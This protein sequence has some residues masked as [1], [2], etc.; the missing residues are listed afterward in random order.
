MIHQKTALISGASRGIGKAIAEK[1]ASQGMIVGLLARN[2]TELQ[3]LAQD[4]EAVGGKALV[5]P[6]DITDEA[7]IQ[8]AVGKAWQIWGKIDLLINNAGIGVFK[9]LMDTSVDD[10]DNVMNTNA[11]GTFLLTKHILPYLKMQR[12]GHIITIASDVSRRNF[13]HGSVYCASK[14]AQDA[15]MQAV[16]QEV[17]G[18]NIK[19][20]TLFPGL[21]ESYFAG[22]EPAQNPNLNRLQPQDIAEAVSYIFYAP[23]HV[24]IDEIHLH[25][26]AQKHWQ[27]P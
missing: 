17:H 2:A 1:L 5:L 12:Q 18:A 27:N 19:V 9:S 23:S 20:S 7:S 15:L 6:T 14:Y 24:V 10:W 21:T 13:A 26:F 11:K 16:R 22:Q 8:Q 25:P 4:I 3:Q